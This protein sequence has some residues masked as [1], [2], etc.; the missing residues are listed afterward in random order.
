MDN[1]GMISVVIPVYNEAETLD[2]LAQRLADVLGALGRPFELLFVDD[3]STDGS[4]GVVERLKGLM[5]ETIELIPLRRNFGKCTALVSGFRRARGE[6]IFTLD[7]DLQDDPAEIPQF[8]AK[9]A[10]GYDLVSGW[11][12]Q[13]QDPP[14]KR[15]ASRLFNTVAARLTGVRLHDFNCGFKCYRREVIQQLELHGRLYR[16]IPILAAAQGFHVT[17]I[18]VRH[19]PRIAGC[20][21]F[22][23]S[24]L[25]DGFF[26]LLTVLMLTRYFQRPLHLLG[27]PGVILGGV[28]L[29][30]CSYLSV[31][32]MMGQSIGHRPLLTLGILCLIMGAQF[33]SIGLL[34]EMLAVHMRHHHQ[35]PPA[36]REEP[37]HTDVLP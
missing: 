6:V 30:V 21:K 16:F 15:W 33:L 25:L 11:K 23:A 20:S 2:P 28:G 35:G 1:P 36:A 19:H 26:D 27:L 17:E 12:V 14:S 29:A 13:R 3:G 32:W 10:E 9:L 31:L 24:R 37:M 8:L 4:A 18:P 5:P 7:A 34:G 22:G